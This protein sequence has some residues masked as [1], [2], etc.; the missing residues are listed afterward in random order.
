MTV[1][2]RTACA[3]HRSAGLLHIILVAMLWASMT[4][5]LFAVAGGHD[6]PVA[7]NTTNPAG[8][9]C[10]ATP[11]IIGYDR[12]GGLAGFQDHVEIH[13]DGCYTIHRRGI[14]AVRQLSGLQLENLKDWSMRWRASEAEH[15]SPPGVSD[16]LYTHFSFVG[17]GDE[18]LD[19]QARR[20][21]EN[22]LRELLH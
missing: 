17:T 12:V 19:P 21:I 20:E 18:P 6:A 13:A 4:T 5:A 1:I 8:P 10:A 7:S 15:T 22:W 11:K 16:R 9:D 14:S 2:P 3:A